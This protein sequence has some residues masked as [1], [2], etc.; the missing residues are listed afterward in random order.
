[1]K[2]KKDFSA[3]FFAPSFFV[4]NRNNNWVVPTAQ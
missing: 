2:M 1:M 4:N 3:G